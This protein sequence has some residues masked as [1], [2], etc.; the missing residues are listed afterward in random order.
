[1]NNLKERYFF[2]VEETF[3]NWNV[4]ITDVNFTTGRNVHPV[5]FNH[6]LLWGNHGEPVKNGLWLCMNSVNSYLVNNFS[7]GWDVHVLVFEDLHDTYSVSIVD[8]VDTGALI[9]P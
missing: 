1:M 6:S 4:E 2:P 7:G 5:N 8:V 3:V 9:V